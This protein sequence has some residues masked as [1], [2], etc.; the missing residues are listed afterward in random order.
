MVRNSVTQ[1]VWSELMADRGLPPDTAT[2]DDAWRQL[3]ARPWVRPRANSRYVTLH[4]ALAEELAQRVIPLH[5]QGNAWRQGLW[6]RAR[7]IYA[8]L[9]MELEE[10]VAADLARIG[11]ALKAADV[12]DEALIAE[13]S[14]VD[15]RK[16]ELDELLTAQLHYAILDDFA[17]GTERFLEL[18]ER[19]TTRRDPLFM[20]LICHEMEVFLPRAEAGELPDEVVDLAVEQYRPLA[21]H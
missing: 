12:R 9:T 14:R 6:R 2:W 3:I 7:E 20:E 5:D 19:A 4:D 21:A 17:A 1:G 15:A 18:C 16:R 13:V 11:E 8:T 10:R